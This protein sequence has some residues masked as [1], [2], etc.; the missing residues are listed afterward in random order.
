MQAPDR[1]NYRFFGIKYSVRNKEYWEKIKKDNLEFEKIQDNY[2]LTNLKNAK[3]LIVFL[4][5]GNMKMSGGVMSIFSL[6]E[7]SRKLLPNS[8]CILS[9]Y[10]NGITYTKN[11]EFPNDEIVYRFSQIEQNCKNSNH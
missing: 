9:T 8:T 7:T 11:D 4:T 1:Q 5:P 3:E 2:D 10:P 6:C